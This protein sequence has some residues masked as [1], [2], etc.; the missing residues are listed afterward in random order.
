MHQFK[1]R[2]ICQPFEFFQWRTQ[3]SIK[4]HAHEI[5]LFPTKNL[6]KNGWF[7]GR[8]MIINHP[9]PVK[10]TTC[11]REIERDCKRRSLFFCF[12]NC[13]FVLYCLSSLSSSSLLLLLLAQG[14]HQALKYDC[15]YNVFVQ[16]NF[17]KFSGLSVRNDLPWTSPTL[18]F[19]CTRAVFPCP[20]IKI[21]NLEPKIKIAQRK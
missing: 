8:R 1:G 6:H 18:F 11:G 3:R 16:R 21:N 20:E 14:L 10:P 2:V 5:Q 9:L 7:R 12:F 4:S 17:C 13:F 19:L 15:F